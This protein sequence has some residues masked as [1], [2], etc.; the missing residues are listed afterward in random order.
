[1]IPRILHLYWGRNRPLS[2]LRYR[3]YETFKRLNPSWEIMVWTTDTP[4]MTDSWTTGEQSGERNYVDWFEKIP[5]RQSFDFERFGFP[6]GASEVHKS[7]FIRW[8]LLSEIGGWW[9]DFDI[10]YARPMTTMTHLAPGVFDAHTVVCAHR[11]H[12]IGFLGA[13]IGS[14]VFSKAAEIAADKYR[15][16]D[17][18]C[19]GRT[20]MDRLLPP[21]VATGDGI[22]NLPESVV[23]PVRASP[24]R[25]ILRL[26]S[27][28]DIPAGHVGVHWYAGHP[29]NDYLETSTTPT[30]PP[31]FA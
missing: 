23:Y 13:Q 18:Q 12:S 4:T 5:V 31:P 17:Y 14:T 28:I 20:L 8:W 11:W 19:I 22:V 6:V 25:D 15:P 30:N 7:D 21:P 26:R 16:R 3:T 24:K 29:D 27:H 1:M 9:S 10:Y 2:Y